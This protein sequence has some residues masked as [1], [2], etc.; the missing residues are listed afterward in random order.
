MQFDVNSIIT[1]HEMYT[2][3]FSIYTN[4]LLSY[5][6]VE[7]VNYCNVD[8]KNSG[9]PSNSLT[10]SIKHCLYRSGVRGTY[11]TEPMLDLIN[12]HG[13]DYRILLQNFPSE[14]IVR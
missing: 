14:I 4:A 5:V 13:V 1:H 6:L 3:T 9:K 7:T 8:L 2:L 11:H 12:I 10:P